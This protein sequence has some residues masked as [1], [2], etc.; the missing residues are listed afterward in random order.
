MT[1]YLPSHLLAAPFIIGA[2]AMIFSFHF[3]KQKNL[4]GSSISG[5]IGVICMAWL[6][7]QMKKER[8]VISPSEI[9]YY[10]G[11]IGK[12]Q[13]T[14]IRFHKVD[15]V[16][17]KKAP[18]GAETWTLLLDGVEKSSFEAQGL[19]ATHS[20]AIKELLQKNSILLK[21]VN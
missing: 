12:S 4:S 17:I 20:T 15:L 6:A 5:I 9:T 10:S 19:W 13:I 11:I 21:Q 16:Q 1:L 14:E 3:Y 2:I 8:I 7:P 18:N